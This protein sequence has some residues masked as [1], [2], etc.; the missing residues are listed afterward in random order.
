VFGNV[1]SGIDVVKAI[2]KV[3][4]GANDRPVTPVV[5]KKVTIERVK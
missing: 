4:T 2:S 5:I 3:K 1:T